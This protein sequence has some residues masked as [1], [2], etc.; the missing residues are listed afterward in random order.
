MYVEYGIAYHFIKLII[1]KNYICKGRTLIL[2]PKLFFAKNLPI[3]KMKLT[4][5]LA[6]SVQPFRRR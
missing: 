5:K 4:K 2:D 3:T 6:K 1:V